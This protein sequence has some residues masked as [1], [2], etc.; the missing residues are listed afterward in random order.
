MLKS[1][2]SGVRHWGLCGALMLRDQVEV[3]ADVK[4]LLKDSSDT[5]R[6]MAA[7]VAIEVNKSEEAYKVFEDLLQSGTYAEL[8]VLNYIDWM[9]K[10][11]NQRLIPAL[12]KYKLKLAGLGLLRLSHQWR[13]SA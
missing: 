10:E 11:N 9:G 4:P 2:D 3:L 7:W 1:S 6:A 8:E 13:S 12:K 5:V